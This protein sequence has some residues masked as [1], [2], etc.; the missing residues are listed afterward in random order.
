MYVLISRTSLSE[1][2]SMEI[3]SSRQK[4]ANKIRARFPFHVRIIYVSFFFFLKLLLYYICM[5]EICMYNQNV[6]FCY[7]MCKYSLMPK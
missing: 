6:Q 1:E 5:Y 2:L 4:K 7:A 3:Q